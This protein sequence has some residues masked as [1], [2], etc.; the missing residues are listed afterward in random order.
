[1]EE[2]IDIETTAKM[3]GCSISSIQNGYM[4]SN[5]LTPV[6]LTNK[7]HFKLADVKAIIDH[8]IKVLQKLRNTPLTP[9]DFF[10]KKNI[11][12]YVQLEIITDHEN[13]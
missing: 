1:M 6:R 10:E 5:K 9:S 8:Q 13:I 2:L 3:L 11:E 4:K 12:G 7:L